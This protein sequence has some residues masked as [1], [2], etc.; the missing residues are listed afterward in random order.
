VDEVQTRTRKPA[1]LSF[2][3]RRL[4]LFLAS[5][6]SSTILLK[7]A[8]IQF[9]E[10]IYCLQLG[11]LIA[12]F[13][14][15]RFRTRL[16][17]PAFVISALYG[18]FMV[19][20][21]ISA[22]AA[23]QNDFYFPS[24]L[25]LLK[26]PVWITFSRIIEL[27]VDVGA[28]VYLIQLFR[29]DIENLIFA[30]RVYFW[31]GV[32]ACVY[33]IVSFPLNVLYDLQL[34]TYVDVHRMRGFFNEGGPFGVYLISELLIAIVLYRQGWISRRSYGV[35]MVLVGVGAVGSQSK[36][37]LFAAGLML[38]F[39]ALMVKETGRRLAVLA[40][41]AAILCVCAYLPAISEPL[42]AYVE[43]P[44]DFEY[45]SNFVY[46]D[47]NYVYGRVAGAFIVPRM[48]AAHPYL[49]VGWGNYGIVRDSPQYRGGAAFADY[50]DAPGLGLLGT[51]AEVGIPATLFLIGILFYPYFYLRRIEA[52][53]VIKN[54]A[55]MQPI[56][57][58]FGGQLNLTHPWVITAFAFGLG[59]FYKH[60]GLSAYPASALPSVVAGVAASG[61]FE[62]NEAVVSG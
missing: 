47:P 57:H 2:Y 56:I 17:R 35:G 31:V 33:S 44:A 11:F 39:N 10:I 20:T 32:A 7:V 21:L 22:L 8:E 25:S 9:L 3:G 34:G 12:L 42:R 18:V 41:V 61:G 30:L 46:S 6:L 29:T 26:E 4:F 5:T 60:H 19:V 49:G 52:P 43:K 15:R 14:R 24:Q 51:A 62:G 54:L 50:D 45:Y 55:L 59:Y 27:T 36:S 28:M 23:L 38:L 48:I 16:F 53:L 13:P 37:A 1:D 58:L 40:G